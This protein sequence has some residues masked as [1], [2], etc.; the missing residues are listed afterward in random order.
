MYSFPVCYGIIRRMKIPNHYNL[1][2]E[3][4]FKSIQASVHF[5]EH[6]SSL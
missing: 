4:P 2:N 5:K 1:V 3:F 6:E